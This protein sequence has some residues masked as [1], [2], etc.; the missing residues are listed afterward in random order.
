M[1]AKRAEALRELRPGWPSLLK[2]ATRKRHGRV[3]LGDNPLFA[4]TSVD[5]GERSLLE[6]VMSGAG[7][8]P[9][10]DRR[11]RDRS[12]ELVAVASWP[13]RAVLAIERRA[14][15]GVAL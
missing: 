10:A 1:A 14:I 8:G 4:T 9:G 2:R 6:V 7:K 13:L 3:R 12:R 15:T 5:F 11:Y